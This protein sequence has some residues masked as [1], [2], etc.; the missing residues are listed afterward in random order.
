MAKHTYLCWLPGKYFGGAEKYAINL[1]LF[2][3]NQN[4]EVHIVCSYYDCYSQ[5]KEELCRA[6]GDA[7]NNINLHYFKAP[8]SLRLFKIP[9]IRDIYLAYIVYKYKTIISKINPSSIHINLP[10]PSRSFGFIKAAVDTGIPITITFHLVPESVLLTTRYVNLFRNISRSVCLTTVSSSNTKN[11]C[12]VLCLDSQTIKTIPNRSAPIDSTLLS[13]SRREQL[14]SELQLQSNSFICTT[15][16][17]LIPRK[18]HED[19]IRASIEVL[20]KDPS[21]CFLF[22][23]TG[24]HESYLKSLVSE[25]NLSSSIF[26]LGQRSDVSDLLQLAHVF[27]FPSTSEG[28]SFALMEAIQHKIPLVAANKCGADEIL[29]PNLHYSSYDNGNAHEL[30]Q[31]L[32]DIKQNYAYFMNASELAY[33]AYHKYD[34]NDMLHDLESVIFRAY[35]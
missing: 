15:V 1:S 13:D 23:G 3:T 17:A 25:R 4:I 27:V 32:L 35:K 8:S 24:H 30:A 29:V 19:I 2:L 11:L 5:L 10:Y 12:R 18:G 6:T 22:I 9:V 16:A 14:Y 33:N 26:F 34:Y 31:K 21:F 20:K 7:T 28:L